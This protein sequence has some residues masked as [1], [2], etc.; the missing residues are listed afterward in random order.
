MNQADSNAQQ[1]GINQDKEPQV[2]K[3]GSKTE[4]KKNKVVKK[5]KKKSKL[6]K[7]KVRKGNKKTKPKR[8]REESSES[9]FEWTVNKPKIRKLQK[10]K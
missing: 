10:D 7:T 5:T 3:S 4:Q 8:R 9:E 2:K 6:N 1:S